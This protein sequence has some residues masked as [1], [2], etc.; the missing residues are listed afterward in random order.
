MIVENKRSFEQNL[1]AGILIVIMGISG[2][3]AEPYG[4]TD[5]VR[6]VSPNMDLTGD[7]A[8]WFE[9]IYLVLMGK[10]VEDFVTNQN[11][12]NI[13]N[14]TWKPN[15]IIPAPGTGSQ[16]A[17]AGS[18]LKA[19]D[20][21]LGIGTNFGS[22]KLATGRFVDIATIEKVINMLWVPATGLVAV[23]DG[24][25]KFYSQ[26]GMKW[27]QADPSSG[28]KWNAVTFAN[29]LW[30][31]AGNGMI[32]Y[33][34]DGK[35]WTDKEIGDAVWETVT[36]AN[37]LWVV[38]GTAGHMA[39][40]Q[41]GK[42]WNMV[43]V[44]NPYNAWVAVTF[45]NKRWAAVNDGGQ[46]AY[47]DNGK[48]WIIPVES[49][50]L[51]AWHNWRTAMAFADNRWVAVGPG[52]MA[53]STDGK[54][55]NLIMENS[56]KWNA[57]TFANGRWVAVGCDGAMAHSFNGIN[58]TRITAGSDDWNAVIFANGR[59]I[60]VGKNGSIARSIDG[61]EWIAKTEG[62]DDW[63]A[64]TFANGRWVTVGSGGAMAY[65]TNGMV[66]TQF[67]V[68]SGNWNAVTFSPK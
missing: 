45:G 57:V 29:G 6:N 48:E 20:E 41:D 35:N 64:A 46:M 49:W 26:D 53:Y 28:G 9:D 51:Y 19:I 2:C 38:G 31:A 55:W 32:G 54:K 21:V 39:Y 56:G 30:V 37:G 44:V 68:G 59:W 3:E 58:W 4:K 60:A 22:S 42:N 18:L 16:P 43:P 12:S 63:N 8:V 47:S 1:V 33:S 62:S 50:F 15:V 52:E 7:S 66:W 36:F 40:S 34:A 23:G 27:T 17:T 11:M 14:K 10:N 25:E 5:I 65:S 67:S 13:I 24:N 61:V